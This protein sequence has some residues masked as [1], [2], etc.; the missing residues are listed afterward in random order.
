M[1]N[2]IDNQNFLQPTG[3]KVILSRKNYPN[4]EFFAQSFQHPD[5]SLNPAV[6]SFSRTAIPY[7]GDTLN[8][9]EISVQYIVDEDL[10]A[11][12][13]IYQ[14]MLRLVNEPYYTEL[15]RL[16]DDTIIPSVGQLS[17][18]VLTSHN[19]KNVTFKYIDAFPT[20]LGDISLEATNATVEPIVA[21]ITFA[22]SY[23]IM[24]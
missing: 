15:D 1:P 20:S 10:K 12:N 21:P 22:Y 18:I 19:N 13:E 24:E 14:W 6:Q 16:K 2:T 4:V 9:S 5:V 23:F 7:P 17:V 3:F 11:Y 8:F